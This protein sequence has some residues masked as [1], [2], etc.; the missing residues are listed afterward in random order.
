MERQA[1]IFPPN[2]NTVSTLK[3]R[4]S[5]GEVGNS[6]V[7]TAGSFAQLYNTNTAFGTDAVSDNLQ[8]HLPMR[9][10]PGKRHWNITW[11]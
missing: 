7:P 8:L 2:S 11:V 6:N 10:L 3:L 1:G 4:A 5:V 9:T